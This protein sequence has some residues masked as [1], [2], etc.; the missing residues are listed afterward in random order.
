MPEPDDN[1]SADADATAERRIDGPAAQEAGARAAAPV[2]KAPPALS[3]AAL[4]EIFSSL[5]I[6]S[7]RN[8]WLGM[9]L[10]MGGMQVQM[11]VRGYF[12]YQLTESPTLLGVVTAPAAVPAIVFGLFGGVLADRVEKKRIIQAGQAVSVLLALFVA[13][14]ITTEVVTWHYLLVSSMIQGGL[15]PVMMPARQSIIPQLV[16][17][18]RLMNAVAL[19]S[20]GRGVTTLFAPA[21]GGG[22]IIALGVDGAYYALAAMFVGSMLLTA[23][24]PK[25]ESPRRDTQT[26][27]MADL[28]DGLRYIRSTTSILL[29][30]LLSMCTT[31]LAMPIRFILPIFAEDIFMV[32]ADGLGLM[33]SAMGLGSLG[34]ALFIAATGRAGRRGLLLTGG[35][36]VTG[37]SLLGFAVLSE[38]A[39]FYAAALGIL[40]VVGL[41]EAGRMTLNNGLLIEYTEDRYRGRVMSV[42][43]LNFALMPMGVLPLTLVADWIGAPEALG[44]MA[45]LLIAISTV[46]LVVSPHLRRLQ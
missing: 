11:M 16:S 8:L 9:L 5:S 32:G 22:F 31:M 41:F 4:K 12:V 29:L 19:N 42:F 43:V 45:L 35:S 26:T 10:Q 18:E 30:L 7:F 24:L 33:M 2:Q 27:I 1:T 25:L 6:A 28:F 40:A 13:I 15:M 23:L 14:A 44:I 37:G 46:F 3:A 34:G 20:M 21:L 17:R 38:F 39:P 36:I